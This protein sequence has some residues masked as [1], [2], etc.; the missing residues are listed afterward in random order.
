V[1]LLDGRCDESDL[2]Q[3]PTEY[4]TGATPQN[5]QLQMGQ[6][7]RLVKYYITERQ[8]DISFPQP[9]PQSPGVSL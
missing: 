5:E 2:K 4:N 3:V 1:E 9:S 7:Q 6:W 8:Y